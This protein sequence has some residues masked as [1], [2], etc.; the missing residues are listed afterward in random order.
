V[1]KEI[2]SSFDVKLSVLI[3]GASCLY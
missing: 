2:L 3:V 1:K